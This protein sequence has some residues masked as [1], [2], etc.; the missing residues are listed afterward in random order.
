[1][2]ASGDIGRTGFDGEAQGEEKNGM[3]TDSLMTIAIGLA[4]LMAAGLLL[5]PL[6]MRNVVLAAFLVEMGFMLLFGRLLH[7]GDIYRYPHFFPLEVP[8]YASLGPLLYQYVVCLGDGERRFA[9][10]DL[11]HHVPA[12]LSFLLLTPWIIMPAEAKREVARITLHN[13]GYWFIIVL[14]LAGAMMT[15]VYL[16]LAI[17]HL[18][19]RVRHANQLQKKTALLLGLL[20]VLLANMLLGLFIAVSLR[21]EWLDFFF[22][23]AAVEIMALFLLAQRYPYVFLYSTMPVKRARAAR[24]RLEGVDRLELER[25]IDALMTDEKIYCDEDLN[26]ARLSDALEVTPHQ[27]SEFIN[28]RYGRNFN[29]FVNAYRVDEA[30]RLLR[31]ERGRSVLSI[32]YAAGFNSY[33]S[34]HRAFR[35]ETG[36]S[37]AEFREGGTTG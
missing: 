4:L 29:R 15:F 13:E 17:R 28:D 35:D 12:L 16:G 20:L 36:M 34:F 27:L 25:Q 6:R 32:A 11:L 33:S 8:V 31:E 2:A 18:W 24:S 30:K 22:P 5:R 23:L 37:P 26:L 19:A 21:M 9:R 1:M 10:A 14:A 7:T 3:L